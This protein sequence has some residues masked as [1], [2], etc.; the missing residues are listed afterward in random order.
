MS[1]VNLEG[2][3][4][5]ICRLCTAANNQGKGQIYRP[6]TKNTPSRLIRLGQEEREFL[7]SW[8]EKVKEM[9]AKDP[10]GWNPEGVL[11]CNGAGRMMRT[12]DVLREMRK[13]YGGWCEMR[14]HD[15]RRTYACNL[16]E[17]SGRDLELVRRSLNVSSMQTVL[18]YLRQADCGQEAL[19]RG[20]DMI[21]G[22]MGWSKRN[23]REK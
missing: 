15:L 23:R 13:R 7:R 11:F 9:Q 22:A 19:V 4:L 10:A 8:M 5:R 6:G 21:Y 3:F 2:G 18:R 16:Y 20:I 17:R 1:D 12:S 14:G